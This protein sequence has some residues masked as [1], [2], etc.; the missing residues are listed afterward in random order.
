MLIG[1]SRC[2]WECEQ[3]G[4]TLTYQKMMV[5]PIPDYSFRSCLWKELILSKGGQITKHDSFDVSSLAK[6]SEGYPS[7]H[8]VQTINN[9]MTE[10]RVLQQKMRPLQPV[11]FISHL[12]KFEPIYREEQDAYYTWVSKLFKLLYVIF[13]QMPQIT[14][15]F[16]LK[17]QY[18][19]T[20]TGKKRDKQLGGEDDENKK[21][22]GKKKKKKNK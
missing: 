19:K 11:E 4:L 14:A 20:P 10:R 22:D 1:A 13:T 8:I 6:V 7:G 21:G 9:T 12:A 17:F 2:P 5:L 16:C 18:S 3:K 15:K